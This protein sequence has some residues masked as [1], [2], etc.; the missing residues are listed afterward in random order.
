MEEPFANQGTQSALSP[1]LSS[2]RRP[3]AHIQ[4]NIKGI[5]VPLPAEG[6]EFKK[7]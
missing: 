4:T 3:A 5:S 6:E 7:N 2:V 1:Y